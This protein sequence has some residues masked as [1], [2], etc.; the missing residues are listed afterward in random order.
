MLGPHAPYTCADH[1]LERVIAGAKEAGV[2]VHI[3]VAETAQEVTDSQRDPA[4][5]RW[6]R[7]KGLGMFEAG[8]CWPPTACT[9][10]TMTSPPW[11]EDKVG[12]AHNP[13]SNMKLA[14]G[15]APCP[16]CSAAGAVVGLGTDGA[17]SNNNLDMLEEARLAALLHKLHSGDPTVVPARQALEMGTRGSARALG[18]G[19]Q[20]GQIRVGIEGRSGLA[21]V[22]SASPL[23]APRSRI[24]PRLPGARRRCSHRL[25]QR[26]GAD[27]GQ[28]APDPGRAG[29]F[30]ASPRPPEAA[31]PMRQ[32]EGAPAAV[33]ERPDLKRLLL[34]TPAGPWGEPWASLFGALT[35]IYAEFPQVTCDN[36]ARCCFESPGLFFIEFL[37]ALN[38]LAGMPRARQEQVLGRAP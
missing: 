17:A 13:G 32:T 9:S 10:A 14:S 5:R 25:R 21:G 7:L 29:D 20:V 6:Q 1:L 30:R 27:A 15:V 35:R 26:A 12:I 18:L 24:T 31:A 4:R 23:P 11:S 19:D 36:C 38:L 2:G 16:G 28:T 3:H 34:R 8:R 33:S 22:P 37:A